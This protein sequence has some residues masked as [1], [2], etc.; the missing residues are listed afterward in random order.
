ME[1]PLAPRAVFAA[2]LCREN[3]KSNTHV[4]CWLPVK[5]ILG[6]PTEIWGSCSANR[7]GDSQVLGTAWGWVPIR[8]V[9]NSG[10][11]VLMQCLCSAPGWRSSLLSSCASARTEALFLHPNPS[12]AP[13]LILVY[14]L[15]GP[16]AVLG[17]SALV[18]RRSRAGTFLLLQELGFGRGSHPGLLAASPCRLLVSP[19]ECV[20]LCWLLYSW[21]ISRF[22][23][24]LHVRMSAA[25]WDGLLFPRAVALCLMGP[26]LG[27]GR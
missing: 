1:G 10:S 22:S 17:C 9:L 7:G 14:V 11:A 16:N 4:G 13:R 23:R 24:V 27:A 25:A 5:P 6:L 18:Q 26:C 12:P 15:Q 2:L 8:R 20:A 3:C 19:L 21:V